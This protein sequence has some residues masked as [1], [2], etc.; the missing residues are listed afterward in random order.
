MKLKPISDDL[1]NQTLKGVWRCCDLNEIQKWIDVVDDT[2]A[3]PVSK[4]R[5]TLDVTE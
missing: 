4:I 5:A 3:H 1:F 2:H